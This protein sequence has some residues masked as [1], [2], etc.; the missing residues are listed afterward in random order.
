MEYKILEHDNDNDLYV[1]KFIEGE[2]NGLMISLYGIG[3]SNEQMYYYY[4]IMNETELT[5][6]KNLDI[7]IKSI[8]KKLYLKGIM[9]ESYSNNEG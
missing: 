2:F 3:F 1:I 8:V 5:N 4:N 7:L 9:N 6:L